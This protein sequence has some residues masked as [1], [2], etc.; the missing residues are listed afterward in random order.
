M[1]FRLITGRTFKQGE[2]KE[3]GKATQEYFENT[4]VVYVNEKGMGELGLDEGSPTEVSTDFGS[5]VVLA[6]EGEGLDKNIIF[7]PI[8]PWTSKIING[9]TEGTGSSHAKGLSANLSATSKDVKS[10]EGI[11]SGG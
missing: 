11:L 3:I 1:I 8:G 7:M 10:L 2:A 9:D 4:A 6:K 5:V